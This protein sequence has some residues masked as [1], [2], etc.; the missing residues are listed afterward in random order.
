MRRSGSPGGEFCCAHLLVGGERAS[1]GCLPTRPAANQA[2][3]S[4]CP[5]HTH[6]L[7]ITLPVTLVALSLEVT[8][9]AMAQKGRWQPQPTW[10]LQ[11]PVSSA[12]VQQPQPRP[13][14]RPSARGRHESWRTQPFA[15][16]GQGQE[17]GVAA[18]AG[19][20]P[21]PSSS[22]AAGMHVS[23]VR[24]WRTDMPAASYCWGAGLMSR[25]LC[26][27]SP[28]HHHTIKTCLC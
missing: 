8:V 20:S 13:Q 28:P 7:Q 16:R 26:S 10:P 9:A 1:R 19:A 23:S 18:P 22:T 15:L 4:C 27:V 2:P 24:V 5:L 14:P 6:R 3:C 12:T 17:Q 11:Q 21:A 25:C